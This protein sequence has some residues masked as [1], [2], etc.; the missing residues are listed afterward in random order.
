MTVMPGTFESHRI[1]VLMQAQKSPT[2]LIKKWRLL[3]CGPPTTIA[4]GTNKLR[5]VSDKTP[6]QQSYTT[7]DYQLL[8][9]TTQQQQSSAMATI[10]TRTRVL[11]CC[12]ATLLSQVWMHSSPESSS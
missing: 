9:G 10:L 1:D 4:T 6:K 11:A 5:M 7:H 8:S 3:L 12:D 2:V